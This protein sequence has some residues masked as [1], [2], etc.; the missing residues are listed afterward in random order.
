MNQN[1]TTPITPID[2]LRK[3]HYLLENDCDS[4]SSIKTEDCRKQMFVIILQESL[5][6]LGSLKQQAVI[7]YDA[8]NS[9]YFQKLLRHTG[10]PIAK[11]IPWII[12]SCQCSKQRKSY[13]S[14][15][16]NTN[17]SN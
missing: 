12:N 14:K 9:E 16:N 13:E 5:S 15:S 2:F 17:H 10:L 4:S 7:L 11:D 3:S 1:Q 8:L 6:E